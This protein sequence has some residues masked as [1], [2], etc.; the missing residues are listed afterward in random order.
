M[1]KIIIKKFKKAINENDINELEKKTG[2]LLP[3]DYREF[4]LQYNGGT[5]SPCGIK[6]V[7]GKIESSIQ[8]FLPL[9]DI[10]DDNLLEEI[11]GITIAGQIPK[12]FIPIA[13][14]PADNRIV[15]AV[16]G[17]K[18]GKVYYWSWD[19]EDEDHKPSCRYMRL[20]ANSFKEL[21]DSI[22]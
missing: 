14:D 4:L 19:E 8:K 16:S 21:L 10:K 5:P 20:I 22:Y 1:A 15:L 18:K 12:D 11:N 7:D 13:V 2:I 6:T 9:A 3:G 17:K